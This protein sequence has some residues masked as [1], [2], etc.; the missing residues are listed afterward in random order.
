MRDEEQHCGTEKGEEG[1]T[2]PARD[3]LVQRTHGMHQRQHRAKARQS[4]SA[5]GLRAFI[6]DDIVEIAGFFSALLHRSAPR[7]CPS[8]SSCVRATALFDAISDLVPHHAVDGFSP[9]KTEFPFARCAQ[10]APC[11]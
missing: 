4:A 11:R 10:P 2:L 8:H 6:F 9:L 7:A 5:F 1:H 3:I